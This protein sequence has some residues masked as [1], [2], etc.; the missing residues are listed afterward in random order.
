MSSAQLHPTS[1]RPTS[2]GAQGERNWLYPALPR[3]VWMQRRTLANVLLIGLFFSLPW[4]EVGGHQAVLLDLPH[5]KLALFGL[6]LWP[7]DSYLLWLTLF[8]TLMAMFL[9]TAQWG[10]LWCGWACPQTIFLEGVFRR[11]E[12]WIEGEPGARRR[13]DAAPWSA[14]KFG[15]K[16]L[17][18]SL[19][20]VVAAHVANTFLCYFASTERVVSMS[21][22]SPG[23]NPA[24][25]AFMAGVNLIFYFDFAWFRE[26]MCIIA[27]P[28]G[29][30]QSVMLDRHS[31]IV[32]YDANRGEARGTK[33]DHRRALAAAEAAGAP[34]PALGDCVDCG[35]CV[36]V[37]PTGIDIRD[38]LQMECVNCTACIDACDEVMVKLERPK[39]LVRYSSLNQLSGATRSA[40]RP[41]TAVY[42]GLLT[43]AIGV[44]A[45][46]A[47]GRKL[48]EVQVVRAAGADVATLQEGKLV[49]HFRAKLVNKRDTPIAIS[50]R[51]QPGYEFLVPLRPWPVP[52][53]Q[54]ATMEIFVK[55]DLKLFEPGGADRPLLVFEHEGDEVGRQRAPLLGPGKAAAVATG[56]P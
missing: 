6:V 40:L 1:D 28:Y 5:R 17:K 56:R 19:Y 31:L 30:W 20:F 46:A 16:V 33:A 42:G 4:I 52:A 36:A 44:F 37:C 50:V 32:G 8:S 43:V 7:Q 10:R 3:G 27:C 18:H 48:V 49:N 39:G 11:I 55:R 47:L 15:R 41:R 12:T 54:T 23:E 13:L 2:I 22:Q 45:F 38:G 24:W 29:R 9:I 14:S 35:R 34:P 25:F 53:G 26:Q 51:P 21:T